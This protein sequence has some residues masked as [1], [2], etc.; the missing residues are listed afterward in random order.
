MARILIVDDH[1]A[2]R[3]GLALRIQPQ[4]DMMVCGEAVD[5]EDALELVG[6]ACRT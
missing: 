2:T 5:V 1:P 4:A 6:S 3:E